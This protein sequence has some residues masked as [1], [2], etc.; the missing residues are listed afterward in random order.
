MVTADTVRP[1]VATAPGKHETLTRERFEERWRAIAEALAREG[2]DVLLVAGRGVIG[3]SG[4][5]MYACG[6]APLLRVAVAVFRPGRLEPTLF[7]PS[8]GDV[9]RVRAGGLL[10]DVRASGEADHAGAGLSVAACAAREAQSMR[11]ARV[12]VAGLRR[13]VSVVEHEEIATALA[14]AEIVDADGTLSRLKS[15]KTDWEL[16]AIRRSLAIGRRAYDTARC[17]A[18]PRRAGA[19]GRRGARAHASSGGRP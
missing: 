4:Y 11:P 2:L 17:V 9:E 19:G 3:H 5:L 8:A 15:R 1:P 10:D 6:Y 12:G 13:F 18:G 16:A 7:V 14:E